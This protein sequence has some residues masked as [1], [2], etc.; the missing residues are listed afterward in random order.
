MSAIFTRRFWAVG[1][2]AL[3]VFGLLVMLVL[4][5][6]GGGGRMEL[7][8]RLP[9]WTF[10]VTNATSSVPAEFEVL[11]RVGSEVRWVRAK[12]PVEF[13]VGSRRLVAQFRTILP[14]HRLHVDLQKDGSPIGNAVY[15]PDQ[16]ADP[17]TFVS[18]HGRLGIPGVGAWGWMYPRWA[19]RETYPK[20]WSLWPGFWRPATEEELDA[21]P[22]VEIWP[23]SGAGP[24][25]V[26]ASTSNPAP[27]R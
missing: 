23:E 14:F 15:D 17:L 11:F 2:G 5:G 13:R 20:P 3:V 16:H 10:T 8:A 21:M 1:V 19:A 6:G 18:T 26:S 25:E 9:H 24:A 27:P 4:S 7:A 22:R 12:T